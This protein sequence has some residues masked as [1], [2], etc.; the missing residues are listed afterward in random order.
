MG[1]SAVGQ[2][3]K[4][5]VSTKLVIGTAKDAHVHRQHFSLTINLVSSGLS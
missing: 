2:S 1:Q 3:S 4:A 5:L